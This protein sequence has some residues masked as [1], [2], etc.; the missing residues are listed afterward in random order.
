MVT[1]S[2]VIW[3]DAGISLVATTTSTVLPPV[4]R[5][6]VPPPVRPT[7]RA[8][9]NATMA[10]NTPKIKRMR[11]LFGFTSVAKSTHLLKFGAHAINGAALLRV[12]YLEIPSVP[13]TLS[14]HC[15][16]ESPSACGS[17]ASSAAIA[18]N[19]ESRLAP[20]LF[21]ILLPERESLTG[22]D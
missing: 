20:A 11:L 12:V 6:F 19:E 5:E 13:C 10:R 16:F 3:V 17:C 21:G 18:K 9:P 4:T 1:R 7:S 15:F 2:A 8:P 22:R 14:R